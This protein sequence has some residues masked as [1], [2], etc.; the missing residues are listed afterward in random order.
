MEENNLDYYLQNLARL[1]DI[2]M[3]GNNW[4]GNNAKE[5]PYDVIGKAWSLLY[6]YRFNEET[7]I[8]VVADEAIQFE[9]RDED[10]NYLEIEIHVDNV[11]IYSC[12]N[13]S[14]TTY[15]SIINGYDENEISKIID[16]FYSKKVRFKTLPNLI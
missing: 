2:S 3:L 9:W 6:R 5:I 11:R 16:D 14:E 1:Y 13:E 7:E 15:Q 10:K 4:N 8:Y 12:N